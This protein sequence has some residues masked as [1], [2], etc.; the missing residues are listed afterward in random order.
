MVAI[1]YFDISQFGSGKNHWSPK[2]QVGVFGSKFEDL[3][4]FRRVK[5]LESLG[6]IDA[7]QRDNFDTIR[8][9]RK[10]HLHLYSKDFLNI[11]SDAIACF[12]SAVSLVVSLV[13]QS[14]ESG[15][16]QI[17]SE[18]GEYLN[19]IGFAQNK[20][21]DLACQIVG[22]I[23]SSRRYLCNELCHPAI[24]STWCIMPLSVHLI[25]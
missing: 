18:F 23:I 11:D 1:L 15:K 24:F 3:G 14:F 21:I 6:L 19:R 20:G 17:N 10:Q 7:E 12:E 25:D 9:K 22:R 5:V 4:Q 2:K 8:S 16:L 13:G